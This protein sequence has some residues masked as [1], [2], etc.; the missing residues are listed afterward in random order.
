MTDIHT[1]PTTTAEQIALGA[2]IR[3]RRMERGLTQTQLAE[4][5]GWVQER[6]SL[7]ENAKYGMPSIPALARLASGLD[8]RLFEL[9]AAAGYEKDEVASARETG[10]S[11]AAS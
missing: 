8:T 7:L 5:V 10:N 3:A 6:I 11:S 9:L 4:R 1:N 2:F